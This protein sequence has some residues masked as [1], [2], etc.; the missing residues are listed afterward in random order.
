MLRERIR[1]PVRRGDM[2]F[3]KPAGFEMTSLTDFCG[4]A[5]ETMVTE[6]E[7]SEVAAVVV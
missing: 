6:S 5:R 4:H 7:K 1:M 3:G 2:R